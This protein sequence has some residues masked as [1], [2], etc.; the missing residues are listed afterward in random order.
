LFNSTYTLQRFELDAS[1]VWLD[2]AKVMDIAP[3]TSNVFVLGVSYAGMTLDVMANNNYL[4]RFTADVAG[5]ITLPFSLPKIVAGFDYPVSLIPQPPDKELTDGPMT[6]EI[7]RI[8][9]ATVHWHQS[10]AVAINGQEQLF[11]NPLADPAV[12][13][14]RQSGKR[15]IRLLGYSRDPAITI[16]QPTPGPLTVLGMSLEVSL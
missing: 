3:L 4:G 15:R 13:A 12:E 1:D 5:S 6:G 16:H 10:T 2:H 8:V 11:F 14:P 9:S 7:R